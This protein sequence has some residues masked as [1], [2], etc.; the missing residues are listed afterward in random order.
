MHWRPAPS[1]SPPS[2]TPVTTTGPTLPDARPHIRELI[3]FRAR[4]MTPLLFAAWERFR[5]DTPDYFVGSQAGERHHLSLH[6]GER[7]QSERPGGCLS[8]GS[9]SRSRRKRRRPTAVF[10]L[11]RPIYVDDDRFR[12]DFAKL[13]VRARGQRRK[14]AKY[15]LCRLEAD[16]RGSPC[17]H[18]TD[19]ATIEHILPQK[20]I[21]RL[22]RGLHSTGAGGSGRSSR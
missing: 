7:A 9:E 12:D 14:L 2:R 20:P 15:I 18:E 19:P 8:L 5:I 13:A 22:V 3:L 1:C 10:D 6:G 21:G 11:L 17:D 4:Q 16:A